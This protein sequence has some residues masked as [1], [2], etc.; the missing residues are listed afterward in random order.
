MWYETGGTRNEGTGTFERYVIE[1]GSNRELGVP[2]MGE[3]VPVLSHGPII[4]L[5]VPGSNVS[6]VRIEKVPERCKTTSN[7]SQSYMIVSLA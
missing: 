3:R 6:V 7:T 5:L 4:N 2:K 1:K